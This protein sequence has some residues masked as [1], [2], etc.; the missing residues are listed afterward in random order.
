MPSFN[1]LVGVWSHQL[2]IFASRQL[3]RPRERFFSPANSDLDHAV[4]DEVGRHFIATTRP[5]FE[6]DLPLP[7]RFA[8]VFAAISASVEEDPDHARVW[9]DWASAMRGE[10]GPRFLEAQAGMTV[11]M[12]DAVRATPKK[13]RA[14][15]EMHAE[16]VAH[17]VLA[18]GEMMAR[19]Q[20]SG[21]PPRDVRRFV[22][23]TL[24]TL[25][26]NA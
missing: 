19:M 14:G 10:L 3:A 2:D 5:P 7:E 1:P 17:L 21:R 8:N 20:I 16:D 4:L 6:S 25:F 22:R 24:R 15:L 12:A 9:F 18:A 11:V 26:P 13:D 23:S